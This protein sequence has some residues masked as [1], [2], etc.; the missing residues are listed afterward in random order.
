[1]ADSVSQEGASKKATMKAQGIRTWSATDRLPNP[2]GYCLWDFGIACRPLFG[3]RTEVAR[4]IIDNPSQAG[5]AFATRALNVGTSGGSETRRAT[6]EWL[7][8]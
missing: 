1:M 8:G 3:G 5:V 6:Y 2:A 4:Q 7:H